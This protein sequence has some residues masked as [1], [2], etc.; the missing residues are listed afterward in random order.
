MR[1]SSSSI[2]RR[3]SESLSISQFICSRCF[4]SASAWPCFSRSSCTYRAA[5]KPSVAEC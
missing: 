4:L 3:A 1:R 5:M 2:L